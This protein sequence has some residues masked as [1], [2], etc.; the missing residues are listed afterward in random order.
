MVAGYNEAIMSTSVKEPK[1]WTCASIVRREQEIKVKY[2]VDLWIQ[3]STERTLRAQPFSQKIPNHP[4]NTLLHVW[5]HM[6]TGRN[7]KH[8]ERFP[9]GHTGGQECN[10]GAPVVVTRRKALQAEGLKRRKDTLV[11]I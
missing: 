8:I 3:T 1:G 7:L 2:R 9:R 6:A 11:L 5:T 10:E 4:F